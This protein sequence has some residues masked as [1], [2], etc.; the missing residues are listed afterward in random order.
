MLT[1]A[2]AFHDPQSIVFRI[3]P[4]DDAS[5]KT[6]HRFGGKHCARRVIERVM[7]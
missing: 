2:L 5:P 1:G 7:E 4:S 6:P 3:L